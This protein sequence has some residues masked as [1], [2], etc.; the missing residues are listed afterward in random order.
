MKRRNIFNGLAVLGAITVG[1]TTSFGSEEFENLM[2]LQIMMGA[3]YEDTWVLS[4]LLGPQSTPFLMHFDLAPGNISYSIAPGTEIGGASVGLS[5]WLTQVD[6][7]TWIGES[8]LDLMRATRSRTYDATMRKED[9]KT[10]TFTLKSKSKDDP[11]D[12]LL[13][14]WTLKSVPHKPNEWT[15]THSTGATDYVEKHLLNRVS[16][17]ITYPDK[18]SVSGG[19]AAT[20]VTS[21]DAVCVIPAPATLAMLGLALIAVPRRR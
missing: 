13:R 21:G 14:D 12:E 1:T 7:S 4:D 15:S 9:D 16:W 20:G 5:A 3:M 19:I 2:P 11:S 17:T 18:A 10:W 6:D 8:D